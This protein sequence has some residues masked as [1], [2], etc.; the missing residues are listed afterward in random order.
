LYQLPVGKIEK[1]ILLIRGQKVVLD[2][3]L[4]KRG[5]GFGLVA[6]A[7]NSPKVIIEPQG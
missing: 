2:A 6:R 5:L 1:A 3:D 7:Q 4:A